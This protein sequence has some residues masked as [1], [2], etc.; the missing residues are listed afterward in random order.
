LPTV[1][2]NVDDL[3]HARK[4]LLGEQALGGSDATAWIGHR[5]QPG[6]ARTAQAGRQGIAV[7]PPAKDS[8]GHQD[9]LLLCL[10]DDGNLDRPIDTA[11]DRCGHLLGLEGSGDA[12]ALQ[13]EAVVVDRS[14]DIDRQHKEPHRFDLVRQMS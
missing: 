5:M 8:P 11:R 4:G 13:P 12:F 7:I 9:A 10:F 2:R 1:A 6:P 14:G 3:P